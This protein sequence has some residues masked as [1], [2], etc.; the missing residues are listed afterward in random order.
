MNIR[1]RPLRRAA[2]PTLLALSLAGCGSTPPAPPPAPAAD[3]TVP[4]RWNA[5]PPPDAEPA[6]LSGWWAGFSDPL[7]PE[8]VSAARAASPSLTS[9]AL[10]IAA[11]RATRAAATAALLPSVDLSASTLRSRSLPQAPASAVSS[12]G[13]QAAWEIDLFGAVAAGRDASQARVDAARAAWHGARV[14]LAAE[15]GN[16]YVA[17][18]GCE[19]QLVQTRVDAESRAETARLTELSARSGFT[20]PADAALARAGAAQARVAASAQAA[21]CEAQLKSLAELTA[22]PETEL[23]PRLAAAQALVP[24]PRPL[25]PPALPAQLLAQRPDVAEAASLVVAAAAE[26]DQARA[27]ENIQLTISGNLASTALRAGGETIHGTTWSL[28][29][30]SVSFP[31]VDGGARR[32]NTTAAQAAYDDAVAGYRAQV[33]RALREVEVSLVTLQSTA[34]REG[35]AR[36]AAQDFEASLRATEARQKGGLASLFDLEAARRNAAAAQSAL[37]DLQR[38]RSSAWI[39]LYRALGGG[40]GPAALEAVTP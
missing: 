19:A 11:A 25:A 36:R 9:A 38:E 1:K 3:L 26:R 29:P 12:I 35:D 21:A 24:L 23:R 32:A 27:R 16:A 39:A 4:A 28:G 37:I 31:L 2:G 14:A 5:P 6:D 7:L 13:V 15:V 8:L 20:A 18:R 17:L 10:R 30:L 22:L 40:F 34:E 33:R